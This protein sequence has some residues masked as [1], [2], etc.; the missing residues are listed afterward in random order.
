M[1]DDDK[2]YFNSNGAPKR[3]TNCE[4]VN[5]ITEIKAVDGG[6]ASEV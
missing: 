6:Q 3:C 1:Y 4:C 2:R 5:L